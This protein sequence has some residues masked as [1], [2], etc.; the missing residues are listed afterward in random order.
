[1]AVKLWM[2]IAGYLA[3]INLA[4]FAVMGVDKSRAKRG[5]W[6]IPEKTLFLTALFG[7]SAGAWA[8]MY[9]FRHKT[10]H[11]RFVIGIPI[12]LFAQLVLAGCVIYRYLI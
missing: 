7:G 6:R 9:C 2:I 12:I 3:V 5:V 10:K 1:M 11:L 4:A 8:G